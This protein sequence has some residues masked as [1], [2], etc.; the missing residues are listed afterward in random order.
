MEKMS[1]NSFLLMP[2]TNPI[3]KAKESLCTLLSLSPNTSP[4]SITPKSISNVKICRI[5]EALKSEEQPMLS[6]A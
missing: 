6:G 3:E 2:F 1:P 5:F 4:K